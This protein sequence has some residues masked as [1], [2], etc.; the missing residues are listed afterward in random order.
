MNGEVPQPRPRKPHAKPLVDHLGGFFPSTSFGVDGTSIAIDTGDVTGDG[1]PDIVALILAPSSVAV[2]A[3]AGDGT[4]AAPVVRLTAITAGGLA[5]GD[6]DGDGLAD[7]ALSD[8]LTPFVHVLLAD[9][10]G[11]LGAPTAF[12]ASNVQRGIVLGDFD[13]DGHRDLATA[14]ELSNMIEV[15]VNDGAAVFTGGQRFF[16]HIRVTAL[17]LGDL[18]GA[19]HPDLAAINLLSDTITAFRSRAPQGPWSS[20]ASGVAGLHG[21]PELHGS[22]DLLGNDPWSITLTGARPNTLGFFVLGADSLLTPFKDGVL[23]PSPDVAIGVPT[24]S[25]LITVGGTWPAGLPSAAMLWM[26]WWVADS[27]A[28]AGFSATAGV[29]ATTP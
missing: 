29:S 24:G 13:G 3:G 10:A 23:V 22:G 6:L 9:G 4:F 27:V 12:A 8:T 28:P 19:G 11:G 5:A 18:D 25:G 7:V 15:F 16:S 14:N 21:V 26:Q 20:V 17:A 1:I 2:L